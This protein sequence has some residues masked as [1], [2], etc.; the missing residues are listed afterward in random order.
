MN[1]CLPSQWQVIKQDKWLFS[2]L[3]WIPILLSLSIWWIF[4]QGIARD[5][6]IGVVDLQHSELSRQLIHHIDATPTLNVLRAYP[7][8]S[9]AKDALISNHIYAYFIIPKHTDRDVY[10]NMPPKVTVFYNS[11]FILIGKVIKSAMLKALGTF[12]AQLSA[13][14]QLAKGDT[15]LQTAIGHAVVIKTQITALFNKNSNYSQFLVSAI[16]PALW[17][18]SIVVSTVLLLAANYRLFGLQQLVGAFPLKNISLLLLF[19]LPFFMLQG[20]LFL[21]CFYDVLAWPMNGSISSLIFIQIFTVIAC[22]IMGH[23]FF[24]LSLDAARAMSLAGAFTAPSFAFMGVTFPV[25][26]MNPVAQL[27]RSLLPIS[28]YIE[29]Q[30][31]Q[32]NYGLSVWQTLQPFLMAMLG[33]SLPLFL[34][35]LL[36]RK[37]LHQA[38]RSTGRQTDVN[39]FN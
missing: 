11:Q 18:I 13:L 3:T 22:F 10:L 7:D 6:P 23:F 2:S 30:I 17:Q 14:K 9:A 26:D 35:L 8:S 24:F 5:L 36:I 25:S 19:Y 4:S 12:N 31:R 27:W 38:Q 37:H 21:F 33:Y 32:A 28:H 20:A 29:A 1:T 34:V 15:P 16:V 39:E